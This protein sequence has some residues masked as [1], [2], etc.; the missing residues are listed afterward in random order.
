[1]VEFALSAFILVI[2]VIEPFALAPLFSALTAL[3]T[4]EQ[5]RRTAIKSVLIAGG[6]L[7]IFTFFGSTV[8]S[9]L[10]IGMPAFRIAGGV[11]LFLIAVDM[12]FVRNSGLRT[13]TVQE[14]REAAQRA[15][16]SVFPLAIPLISGPGA[17]TT[18]MLLSD[19]GGDHGV[20]IVLG[21]V[22]VVLAITLAMFFSADRI[23]RV[24]GETG[25]NVITRVMG[26][27]LAALAMQFVIDGMQASFP[28]L[29]S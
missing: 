24:L 25:T 23:Q 8:L 14:Q 13:T 22:I 27:V 7:A 16:I 20:W 15:D 6:L 4:P 17:L 12:L 9:L 5:R 18:V 1:M 21:V 19:Q 3:E 29:V 2:V 11:L 10:G 28:K 26:I